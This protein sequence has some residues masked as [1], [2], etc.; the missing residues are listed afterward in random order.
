ML[1]VV[2]VYSEDEAFYKVGITFLLAQR[3]SRLKTLYKWRTLARYSSYNAGAVWG[4]EQRLHTAF[5]HLA[6]A[7]T[8]SF[9]GFTDCYPEAQAAVGRQKV[10]AGVRAA[11]VHGPWHRLPRRPYR[12]AARTQCHSTDYSGVAE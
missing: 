4:L 7:P 12:P 10:D 5:A 8:A 1:N 2:K 6:Y 9:S 3:F 11:P